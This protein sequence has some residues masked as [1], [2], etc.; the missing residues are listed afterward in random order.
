MKRQF[1]MLSKAE[2]E[3]AKVEESKF[4]KSRARQIWKQHPDW[5]RG[6]CKAISEK[7]VQIGMTT[8]QVRIAWGRPDSINTTV[9]SNSRH[10]QWVWSLRQFA[11]FEDGVLTP[12]Q[13]SH[14]GRSHEAE[15]QD[16]PAGPAGTLPVRPY[17]VD[18][19]QAGWLVC[20]IIE[21]TRDF[22][23]FQVPPQAK[24]IKVSARK[25]QAKWSAHTTP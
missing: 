20:S 6:A 23:G 7:K 8:E 10:E 3:K 19:R 21:L 18:A 2:Q 25:A 5:P 9:M 1:V 15:N 22:R 13:Q 14:G 24:P 17:D 4:L 16:T 12:I 11:Y